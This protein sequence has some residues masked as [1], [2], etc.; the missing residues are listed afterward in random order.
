[1]KTKLIKIKTKTSLCSAVMFLICFG[2]ILVS[3]QTQIVYHSFNSGSYRSAGN[4]S[5]V[6]SMLGQTIFGISGIS[7]ISILSGYTSFGKGM[8]SNVKN[9]IDN[10]P[11]EFALYQNYPNPFNP[12]TTIRYGVPVL[13]RVSLRIYNILGQQI[14]EILNTEQTQGSY[15]I[16]WNANGAS[17]VY[18]YRIDA[19]STSD[20]NRK[21]TQLKKMVLLK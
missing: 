17:G 12:S 16:T 11:D 4:N 2:T 9:N 6:T 14:S 7:G 21:F 8:I 20:P 15:E 1:M 3:S 5:I 10:I 18:F 13:S 19:V